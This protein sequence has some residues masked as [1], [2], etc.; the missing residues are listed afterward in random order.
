MKRRLLVPLFL[1]SMGTGS[2]DSQRPG[3]VIPEDAGSLDGQV[4]D[5]LCPRSVPTA[6]ASCP[7]DQLVC[8]YPGGAN[9]DGIWH[10][11]ALCANPGSGPAWQIS[12]HNERANCPLPGTDDR[13]LPVTDCASRASQPC[14]P[15]I[16]QTPQELLTRQIK[17]VAQ[18]CG[19]PPNE[20]YFEVDFTDGC[21]SKL[22]L[23]APGIFASTTFFDCVSAAVA[24]AR[25]A[26]AQNL[27]CAQLHTSTLP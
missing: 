14:N 13:D 1:V 22:G 19:G 17:D 6:G 3:S 16:T 20:S 15:M 10:W 18:A 2:C 23:L 4:D 26:C 21:P 24:G 11:T 8:V 5:G 9:T 25:F 27:A 7:R 12:M